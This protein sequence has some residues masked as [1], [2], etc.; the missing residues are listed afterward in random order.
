MHIVF[1]T[2]EYPFKNFSHGGVGSFLKTFSS[3]LLKNGLDVSIVFFNNHCEGNFN[4]DGVNLILIKNS[5]VRGFSWYLNY[6]KLNNTLEKLHLE[7][8]ISIIE[9]AEMSFFWIRKLPGVKY[10]IRLHGGHHFFSTAENRNINLWKGIQEKI[11]FKRSDA[12]IGVSNFSVTETSKYLNFGN[13]PLEIICYSI[14]S[15]HFYPRPEIKVIPYSLAFAGTV[16]EKKG[17]RQLLCALELLIVDFPYVHLNLYGRDWSYPNGDSYM[18]EMKNSFSQI[19]SF[20]TFHGSLSYDKLPLAYAEAEI[21]I[22]PSHSETQG[23][24]APEAMAMQKPVIFTSL[25]PGPETIEHGINGWLCNPFDPIDIASKIREA[26]YQRESFSKIGE[27]AKRKAL[28]KFSTS[29]NVKKNLDFYRS[30]SF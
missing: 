18:Q 23:L 20:F 19:S 12:F 27:N 8:P 25:G 2:S 5:N 24:V 6:R 3:E 17:V 10:V 9:G 30:L 1:I 13:K 14:S 29:I 26:F 28:E 11:S 22:F 21:C 16:C 7:N 4:L 15:D